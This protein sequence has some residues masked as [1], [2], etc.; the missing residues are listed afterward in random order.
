MSPN[1]ERAALLEE[2][3]RR[4]IARMTHAPTSPILAPDLDL[5]DV[6][7]VVSV[8]LIPLGAAVVEGDRIVELTAGDVTVDLSA[9]ASGV[10]I[11]RLAG[12]DEE[13]RA[14]QVLGL[15]G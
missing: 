7:V 15:I 13:I 1:E 5:G 3:P 9:P 6:S 12:E 11:E 2:A 8:W 4:I 10:L 14:G